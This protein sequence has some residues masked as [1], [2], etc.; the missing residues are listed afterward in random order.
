[1]SSKECA[2]KV[3]LR[4]RFAGDD[5]LRVELVALAGSAGGHG[6]A[7]HQVPFRLVLEGGVRVRGAAKVGHV[8]AE[9]TRVHAAG[10]EGAQV[11][12]RHAHKT[13]HLRQGHAPRHQLLLAAQVGAVQTHVLQPHHLQP[14]IQQVGGVALDA[15]LDFRFLICFMI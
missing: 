4:R 11:V 10:A 12:S 5:I 2:K 15:I 3:S 1:L 13:H 7:A 14:G 9:A 6:P 8:A